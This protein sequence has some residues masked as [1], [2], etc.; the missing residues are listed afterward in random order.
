MKHHIDYST[1]WGPTGHNPSLDQDARS[2]TGSG[3]FVPDTLEPGIPPSDGGPFDPSTAETHGSVWFFKG[4]DDQ[5]E[6]MFSHDYYGGP[7]EHIEIDWA[8][9]GSRWHP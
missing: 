8:Y 1:W 2:L 6:C 3:D 9:P 7:G 5:V 4:W